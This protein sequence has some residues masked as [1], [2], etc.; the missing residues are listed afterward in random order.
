MIDPV[1]R[2]VRAIAHRRPSAAA[3]RERGDPVLITQDTRRRLRN[4]GFAFVE[5]KAVELNGKQ[6]PVRLWAPRA[7]PADASS[8]DRASAAVTA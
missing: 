7:H 2:A 5:R 4:E 3:T 6:V 1:D 8:Q